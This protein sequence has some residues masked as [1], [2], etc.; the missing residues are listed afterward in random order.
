[1]NLI[2]VD[3]PRDPRVAAYLDIRERDLVGRH[4]RFVA[5][6]KVVLD[7]LLSA[8]RFAAESALILE[9]RRAGLEGVLRKAP[10]DLP[11]Y[12][13]NGD[14]MDRIAGFHMHRGV[15]AIGVRGSPQPAEVLLETWPASALV[16]VLV[17]ISNHD[18]MGSIFRNAAAFGADAVLLDPT[19][20]DPLYRKAIRV[21]VGAALKV[22]FGSFDNAMSLTATLDRMGF[23]QFALS[24]RGE[25]DIRAAE[26]T[27][28]LALFLGTEGE[29][30]PE[31][32]L[33]RLRTVRIGMAEGFD[34][35]N[36]AAASAIALHH[37]S[38]R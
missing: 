26:R 3:D 9:N 2:P 30:L 18:N 16:V 15:L 5:E 20:C 31:T 12:V 38:K 23:A 27:S 37:F 1:M 19:C 28:R 7:L 32:L 33:S 24:P 22:P 17:G 21:S 36:V 34:S 10:A 11:I 4:G 6:G 35:L 25:T 13:V 8:G 14:V 29:G